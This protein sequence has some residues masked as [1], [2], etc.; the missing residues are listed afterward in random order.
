MGTILQYNYVGYIYHI[1]EMFIVEKG[2]SK[3]QLLFS[4]SLSGVN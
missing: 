1:D 2:K 3:I 4:H